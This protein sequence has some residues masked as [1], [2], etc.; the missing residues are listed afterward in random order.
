MGCDIH[1]YIE[2]SSDNG[3]QKERYWHFFGGRINPGRNYHLFGRI[4]GVRG[5]KAMIPPRG[6]PKDIGIVAQFAS[7][8][9]VVED[10]NPR[11]QDEGCCTRTQA[12]RWGEQYL[13]EKK[14]TVVHPD[15]HSHTWLTVDEWAQAI[16]GAAY[17]IEYKAMLAAM[18]S[19]A[20]SGH[21]VRVV[22]WFDN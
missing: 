19:L 17:S 22:I 18:R 8:L 2:Y 15:W 14:T 10:D 6:L 21:D 11:A 20:Q 5:G 4:A 7:Q 12:T 13:D 3:T 16:R 1:C 9:T